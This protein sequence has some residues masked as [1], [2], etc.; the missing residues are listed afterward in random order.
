MVFGMTRQGFVDVSLCVAM[1]L[2]EDLKGLQELRDKSELSELAYPT[3]MSAAIQRRISLI[4]SNA[5]LR[6]SPSS[7]TSKI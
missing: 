3:A 4:S 2:A 7:A 6:P 5:A 1:G